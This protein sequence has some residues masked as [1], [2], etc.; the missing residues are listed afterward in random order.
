MLFLL[1]Y[2]PPSAVCLKC[3]TFFT[4]AWLFIISIHTCTLHFPGQSGNLIPWAV[5]LTFI[6]NLSPYSAAVV[7][8]MPIFM[9]EN[10]FLPELDSRIMH[11][12]TF[13]NLPYNSCNV[14]LSLLYSDLTPLLFPRSCLNDNNM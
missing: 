11:V 10:N 2:V 14:F 4:G 12:S 1:V 13:K 6:L 8:A 7:S 3:I 5:F 9:K